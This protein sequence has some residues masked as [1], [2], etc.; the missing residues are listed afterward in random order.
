MIQF[1]IK[2]PLSITVIVALI[3]CIFFSALIFGMRWKKNSE[4]DTRT[5][6]IVTLDTGRSYF[7][8]LRNLGHEYVLLEDAFFLKAKTP[9]GTEEQTQETDAAATNSDEL[10]FT[11]SRIGNQLYQPVDD[12]FIR[13]E[14]I[15]SWQNLD[16]ESPVVAA[17]E[18]YLGTKAEEEQENGKKSKKK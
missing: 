5:Y 13:S 3:V 15:A 9:E 17:I 18:E 16:E 8:S 14:T 10:P 6:Q 4:I 1:S 2:H 7:G 12:L 11:L